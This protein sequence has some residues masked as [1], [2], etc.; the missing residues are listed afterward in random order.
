MCGQLLLCALGVQW[1]ACS[2]IWHDQP[3]RPTICARPARNAVREKANN[4]LR[5]KAVLQ[6]SISEHPFCLSCSCLLTCSH[7]LKYPTEGC[8]T[9]HPE[10][11]AGQPEHWKDQ[12]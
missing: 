1:E 11:L 4:A 9:R 10:S 6:C 8:W 7:P 2:T 5:E 3:L 12:G